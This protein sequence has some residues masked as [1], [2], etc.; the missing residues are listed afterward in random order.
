M[1]QLKDL[2][3]YKKK[4]AHLIVVSGLNSV[5]NRVC[6]VQADLDDPEFVT[7]VVDELYQRGA[8]RVDVYWSYRPLLKTIYNYTS[9]RELCK[10]Y[11]PE[12]K[13]I[14]YEYDEQIAQLHLESYPPDWMEG[15]D[16]AKISKTK[17]AHARAILPFRL[18]AER[19]GKEGPWCIAA[20]PGKKWAKVIFPKAKSEEEAYLL[21]WEKVITCCRLEGDPVKNW[22]EYNREIKARTRWLN[23]LKIKTLHYTSKNGTD[24]VVGVNKDTLFCGGAHDDVKDA[25]FNPNMPAVECFTTPDRLKTEGVVY[26][27]RPLSRDGHVMENFA[28]RFHKGK[29]IKVTAEKGERYLKRLINLE[30]ETHYLG[31][32]ALV[33]YD[34]PV[35]NTK[36]IY[37]NTLFDENAACHLAFGYAIN[38][39]YKNKIRSLKPKQLKKLG[40]NGGTIH[41]DFMIGTSD[42]NIVATTQD[43]K[44]VQIFKNG[45]W[46]NKI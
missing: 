30:K 31:E 42:L 10:I 36:I 43:N 27:T 46:V 1:I 33:P 17:K 19:E 20:L 8:R 4:Y 24:L 29:I 25:P 23:N 12:L 21:M 40:I 7:Y 16:P 22:Q 9:R 28:I 5:Q 6:K 18:K 45:N 44:K 39:T 2:T 26:S 34:S 38:T 11:P 37:Y 13:R 14:E 15:I 32:L 35:S 41:I 3:S